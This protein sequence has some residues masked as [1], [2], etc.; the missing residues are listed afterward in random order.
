MF[1]NLKYLKLIDCSPEDLSSI[2]MYSI[3]LTQIEYFY[4]TVRQIDEDL[5]KLIN[6]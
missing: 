2:N 4:I 6:Y 1:S 5:S 3:N